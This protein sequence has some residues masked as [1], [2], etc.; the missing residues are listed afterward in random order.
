MKASAIVKHLPKQAVPKVVISTVLKMKLRIPPF[1]VFALS[2][3]L[4]GKSLFKCGMAEP[5]IQL[6]FLRVI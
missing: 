5:V 2:G 4:C 1:T 6:P 3:S